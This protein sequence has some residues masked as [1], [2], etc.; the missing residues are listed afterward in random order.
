M[1]RQSLTSSTYPQL[2]SI[3]FVFRTRTATK[4]TKM[5]NTRAGRA[6]LLFLLIKPIVLWR[7]RSRRRRP[8]VSSLNM[9]NKNVQLVS[10]RNKSN[11]DVARFTSHA[12]L[13]SK[14]KN[15][16]QVVAAC[17]RKERSV[18]LSATKSTDCFSCGTGCLWDVKRAT[19]LTTAKK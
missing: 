4:C 13:V 5:Q 2:W 17:C 19:S 11:G 9:S 15:V 14:E 12:Q 1:F 7:S 18:L 3:H 8:C 16:L 10:L 6:E